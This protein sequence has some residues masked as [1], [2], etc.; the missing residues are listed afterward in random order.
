V[1]VGLAAVVAVGAALDAVVVGV[2]P[3]VGVDALGELCASAAR[4]LVAKV[5]LADNTAAISKQR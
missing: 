4:P 1:A 2:V 3:G 5:E